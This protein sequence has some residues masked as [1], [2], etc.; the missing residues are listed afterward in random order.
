[1]RRILS[2]SG[3]EKLEIGF[4][5]PQDYIGWIVNGTPCPPTVFDSQPRQ[6]GGAARQRELGLEDQDYL[7]RQMEEG[8]R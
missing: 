2:P 6:A 8:T 3:E 5:N 1:V 7:R 4:V